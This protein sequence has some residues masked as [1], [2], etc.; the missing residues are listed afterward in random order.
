[1]DKNNTTGSSHQTHLRFWFSCAPFTLSFAMSSCEGLMATI[2]PCQRSQF[3]LSGTARRCVQNTDCERLPIVS[4]LKILHA[5][6]NQFR[7]CRHAVHENAKGNVFLWS[8]LHRV[9]GFSATRSVLHYRQ[10][11]KCLQPVIPGYGMICAFKGFSAYRW[12][13]NILPTVLL[14]RVWSQKKTS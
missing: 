2:A 9:C 1:M 7:Y 13:G 8:G 6:V 5:Y 12:S 10:S 14:P 11:C 3:V 4:I